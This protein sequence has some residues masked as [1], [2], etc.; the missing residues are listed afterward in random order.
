MRIVIDRLGVGESR[1]RLQYF[2]WHSY[3][4]T[5]FMTQ[6]QTGSGVLSA[7]THTHTHK[8]THQKEASPHKQD[9]TVQVT[10]GVLSWASWQQG[11]EVKGACCM[12]M[13]IRVCTAARSEW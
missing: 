11:S 4:S 10:P 2:S 6:R 13:M 5:T 3:I 1:D 9:M 7:H 12:E 8:E